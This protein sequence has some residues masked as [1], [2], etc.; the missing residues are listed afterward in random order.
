LKGG[1]KKES[2]APQGCRHK[3]RKKK[4]EAPPGFSPILWAQKK[5]MPPPGCCHARYGEKDEA[6]MLPHTRHHG[7]D[8]C[9]KEEN[10]ARCE[11]NNSVG[12]VA[13]DHEVSTVRL[14]VYHRYE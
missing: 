12:Q 4:K 5:F 8:R 7:H 6:A 13:S 10:L 9:T 2:S 11:E 1:Q 14:F 3:P